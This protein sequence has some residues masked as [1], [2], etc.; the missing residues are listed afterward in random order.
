MGNLIYKNFPTVE[1]T[2]S[3]TNRTKS[4]RLADVIDEEELRAELDE[5]RNLCYGR[6]EIAFLWSQ[7]SHK[8]QI[9]GD[10][11]LA[12]LENEFEL[13]PYE[14][15]VIDGQ[16]DLRFTGP[17]P[18][19]SH[20]EIYA[21]PIINELY[22]R[23]LEQKESSLAGL[24]NFGYGIEQLR[25]KVQ[26]L[27]EHPDVI[28]S[29]FGTRR[30]YSRAWHKLVVRILAEELSPKQFLGTSNVA[31]AMELGLLAT[32]T[33]AHELPMVI[34]ALFRGTEAPFISQNRVLHHWWNEYGFGLSIALT[35]TLGTSYF[36]KHMPLEMVLRW[37]G[38]RQ[39]SGD[40]ISF[41]ERIITYYKF[42]GVEPRNKVIIFSD[43]LDI[44][45]MLRIAN[46]FK[47]CIRTTFGW[48]TNLTNDRARKA[49]SLV[50][51]AVSVRRGDVLTGTVK[52]SDNLE[53]AMGEL[54]DIAYYKKECGY[55][56]TFS[57]E[58]RY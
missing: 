19:V 46:H 43:G 31:L 9:L 57:E 7:R 39:D 51:K 24:S 54:E 32:G 30:R 42:I 29:D 1:V 38:F 25:K 41:G 36:L 56:E 34:G 49:L 50:I 16:F 53:K 37:K 27:K 44:E 3:L 14:L 10:E 47:G 8:G 13:P 58:C 35:D 52:L 11:Y 55:E 12:F 48:G 5:V 2:F 22:F 21:L 15:D 18:S 17:W 33:S 23:S 4:V 6:E 45:A 26:L 20:W 28:F 40:P